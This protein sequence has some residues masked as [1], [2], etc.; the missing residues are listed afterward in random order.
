MSRIQPPGERMSDARGAKQTGPGGVGPPGPKDHPM[1]LA[2]G[3]RA[4]IR[5]ETG[6]TTEPPTRAGSPEST[7]REYRSGSSALSTT[8]AVPSR[9]HWPRVQALRALPFQTLLASLRDAQ[10]AHD[11]GHGDDVEQVVV[12]HGNQP[13]GV[14]VAHEIVIE[15]GNL[16]ARHVARA[17][18]A[19]D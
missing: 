7:R 17:V 13:I 12:E 2:M 3:W 6:I 19:A 18:P 1:G 14:A 10:G 8:G 15:P 9:R 16:L 4:D 11:L 5:F